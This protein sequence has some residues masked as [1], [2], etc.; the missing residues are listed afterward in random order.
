MPKLKNDKIDAK[1]KE[2]DAKITAKF[3]EDNANIAAKFNEDNTKI[4][5]KFNEEDIKLQNFSDELQQQKAKNAMLEN[6]LSKFKQR[7]LM[8]EAALQ[9]M[10]NSASAE[11]PVN[12]DFSFKAKELTEIED[13]K[14]NMSLLQDNVKTLEETNTKLSSIA[15]HYPPPSKIGDP[16]EIMRNLKTII[17]N[18]K[19]PAVATCSK[20]LS[21]ATIQAEL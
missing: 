5:A 12:D 7:Q 18:P 6:E 2:E 15:A 21:S 1:F 4:A 3:T 8:A 17:L 11:K 10:G 20:E 9:E 16:P 14:N 19:Y 13:L